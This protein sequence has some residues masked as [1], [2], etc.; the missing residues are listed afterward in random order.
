[1]F[2]WR[3]K[4]DVGHEGNRR[5]YL[6]PFRNKLQEVARADTILEK[7][8][9]AYAR[10]GSLVTVEV[11]ISVQNCTIDGRHT[12]G[13]SEQLHYL[14]QS[15]SLLPR[16]VAPL[17]VSVLRHPSAH[18]Q[19]APCGP[20]H[21]VA[22]LYRLLALCAAS[23]LHRARLAL[24][25]LLV[26]DALVPSQVSRWPA[27]PRALAASPRGRRVRL[28]CG[29]PDMQTKIFDIFAQVSSDTKNAKVREEPFLY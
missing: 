14:L 24:F 13:A 28:P 10:S 15:I 12:Q 27:A 8:L 5:A 4:A 11:R 23:G 7:R 20:A 1:M 3:R 19:G 26:P 21:R 2:P 9:H 18:P 6:K 29:S 16:A 17:S 25:R 22:F